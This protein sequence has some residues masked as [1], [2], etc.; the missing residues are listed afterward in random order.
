MAD[1]ANQD[2]VLYAYK[3]LRD[4]IFEV[5][6]INQPSAKFSSSKFHWQKLWLSCVSLI[7]NEHEIHEFSKAW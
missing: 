1:V 4:V 6:A 5:F 7:R 3:I 2:R